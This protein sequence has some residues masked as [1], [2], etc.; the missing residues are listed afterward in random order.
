MCY[1][2]R[3]SVPEATRAYGILS[4]RCSQCSPGETG[5]QNH[6]AHD[7]RGMSKESRGCSL[8]SPSEQAEHAHSAHSM[9]LMSKKNLIVYIDPQHDIL[10]MPVFNLLTRIYLLRELSARYCYSETIVTILGYLLADVT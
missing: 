5:E 9:R 8:C 4:I 6:S 2:L 1:N 10:M 3:E 7:P